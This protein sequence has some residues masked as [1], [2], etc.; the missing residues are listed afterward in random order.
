MP[1]NPDDLY[2]SIRS[3][4]QYGAA[5]NYVIG[6]RGTGK[7]YGAIKAMIELGER[8]IFMRRTQTQLEQVMQQKEIELDSGEKVIG[9]LTP[10]KKVCVDN[11]WTSRID[12]MSKDCYII[13]INDKFAGYGVSLSTIKNIKGFDTSECN[14]IIYDEFIPEIHEKAM[15]G[16]GD[17]FLNAYE[18]INR[19]RELEG[20]PAVQA[21]LLA[22]ST[23]IDA[24]L[25]SDLEITE[26]V[27]RMINKGKSFRYFADRGYTMSLLKA[28]AFTEAK[29]NTV[30]YK[31][32][33]GLKFSKMAFDTRVAYDD[34]SNIRQYDIKMFRPI[35]V[36]GEYTFYRHK[37]EGWLYISKCP[38]N[39]KERYPDNEYGTRQV[40]LSYGRDLYVE[41]MQNTMKFESYR[42][43]KL[44][45]RLVS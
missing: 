28:K 5:F 19:N 41:Y 42:C 22:N 13:I 2:F 44:L 12:R 35:Y 7:T 24:P 6:G 23:D 20:K 38:S 9:D 43:K 16:E 40:K 10:F 4:F 32:S 34:F 21:F 26:E 36:F 39:C 25:L 30:L 1:Y 8:F 29:K 15:R 18:T 11:G 45:T 33:K 27:E 37:S 14:Y 17:A 3:L 31:F